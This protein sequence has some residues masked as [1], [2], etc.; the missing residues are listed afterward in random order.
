MIQSPSKSGVGASVA[1]FN[2]KLKQ[3]CV[4]FL[5]ISVLFPPYHNLHSIIEDGAK[6][7]DLSRLAAGEM[8]EW[9]TM[10]VCPSKR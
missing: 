8:H 10:W 2:A 3:S 6:I 4:L 9:R 5:H 1:M 7:E